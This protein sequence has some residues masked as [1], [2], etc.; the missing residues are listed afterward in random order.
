MNKHIIPLIFLFVLLNGQD[1][2][3]LKDIKLREDK[4]SHSMILSLSRSP[5]YI[6]AE[7]YKPPSLIITLPN[8]LWT[9]DDFF[10]ISRNS[11]LYEFKVSTRTEKS[12]YFLTEVRLLFYSMPEYSIET[13]GKEEEPVSLIITWPKIDHF[14]DAV[15]DEIAGS[16]LTQSV[17]LN[18]KNANLADV[19]RLI[20]TQN[21]L[22]LVLGSEMEG[23]ITILLEDVSLQ[24]ALNAIL[25]ISGYDWFVMDNIIIVK[26]IDLELDGELKT[27]IYRLK[28]VE[29][30]KVQTALRGLITNR[31]IVIPFSSGLDQTYLDRIMITDKTANFPEIESMIN[32]LDQRQ[33]QIN[34]SVK[35][36]ETTLSEN[37][38]MGINWSLRTTTYMPVLEQGET[39]VLS[40]QLDELKT[41]Q[42]SLP[43][44]TAILDI[45]ASDNSAKL[46]QEPQITTFNN[47]TANIR[48]G[49]SIPI[50]VPQ[51][52]G[53]VFGTNPYTFETQN[54]N[55]ALNVLPRING[56]GLIS[57][58]VDAAIEAIIGYTGPNADRPIVS[59]R[60]TKT[61]VMVKDGETLLIG[62]LIFEDD[63]KS[64]SRFPFLS[65]I[66]IIKTL[67]KSEAIENKQRELLIFI[68]PTIIS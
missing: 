59:S 27:K 63:S 9:K 8:V 18:F 21:N 1:P 65:T 66:P 67:F 45:L 14:P 61:N 16:T 3:E 52:E 64:R 68:T 60:S 24:T 58:N 30:K 53:S 51:G 47:S 40:D 7:I 29:A 62:G 10:K 38:R 19:V 31:A 43:A 57:M 2:I 28:F 55:I 6:A 34:I 50:L 15:H 49:T 48:I 37:E 32:N 26:P 5:E 17:S 25:K 11:S 4:S 56:E 42:L 12:G 20:A 13:E 36:I 23:T 41:A 22:N 44:A 33:Q 46:L 54:V 35:F 39:N